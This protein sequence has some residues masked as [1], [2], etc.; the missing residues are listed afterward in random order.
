[1]HSPAALAPFPA[2]SWSLIGRVAG[3]DDPAMRREA[4]GQLLKQYLPALRARLVLDR[5]LEADRA[6]D[7]LQGF[8]ADKIVEQELV[9]RA[10][11]ERGKFRSFV[12]TALDR[13]LI[14]RLRAERAERAGPLNQ[15]AKS[16]D[17]ESPTPSGDNP[18]HAFVREWARQVVAQAVRRLE[19]ECEA[20]A[21]LDLWELFRGR[22]LDCAMNGAE[23]RPYEQ[24]MAE[25]GFTSVAEASN[26]LVTAKRMFQRMLR[27]VV[28]DYIGDPGQ[29]EAEIA[30]VRSALARS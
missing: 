1:M 29:V 7:V 6:E 12:L 22:V 9:A 16:T 10:D 26:A 20:R 19:A 17:L 2:T 25:F 13:Y 30:D 15:Q 23:P 18:S 4:L 27:S 14:D 11:R 3:G 28:A 8:I 24:F 21:R 5:R